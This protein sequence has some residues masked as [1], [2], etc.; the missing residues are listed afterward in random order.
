MRRDRLYIG[1]SG[2]GYTVRGYISS[3]FSWGTRGVWGV[4]K[5][6]F[7]L[8]D[9]KERKLVDRKKQKNNPKRLVAL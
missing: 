7:C 5:F 8:L 3:G 4:Q 2:H 6:R 9:L 1:H